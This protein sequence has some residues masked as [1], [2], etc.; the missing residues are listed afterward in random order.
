MMSMR[1]M[2]GGFWLGMLAALAVGGLAPCGFAADEAL[3]EAAQARQV[4]EASGVRGG[5]VVHLGCG[6]GRL[7]A[8]LRA[9]DACVVHGLDADAASVEKAR[10]HI[11]A[12]GLYGPVSVERWTDPAH[13]PY[14]DNLV[15]LLVISDSGLQIS[16][17]KIPEEE[18]LRVLAPLGVAYARGADGRWTK[19]VK[20]WPKD[21]DE[22]THWLHDAGNNAVARDTRVGPPRRMQWVAEPLWS[23]GHEVVS[24]VGGAVTARGRIVYALDEG[25]PG[26]YAL[27]SK[28]VLVA[29]DAFNGVLLWKR[30]I[31]HWNP[32][33]GAGGFGNGFRPRRLVTDGERIFLP[34]GEEAVLTSLGAATGKSLNT[35]EQARGTSQILCADGLLVA[36]ASP[37]GGA[38]AKGK[39]APGGAPV[40]LA[41]RPDTLEVLW[42]MPVAGLAGDTLA[43]GGGRV[44]FMSGGEVVALDAAGGREAWRF[45][46]ARAPADGS[47]KSPGA[48][49]VVHDGAVYVQ[50]GTRLAALAAGTGKEL[51]SRQDAPTSKGELFAAGGL[52]WRTQGAGAVGHDPATGEVRKT[53]D[54]SD[55]FCRGH[56]LR[57]YPSKAT[58]RYIITNNR[59]AEFVSLAAEGNVEND[60]LR[61]NCGHGVMPANGLVY[62]PPCQCMCYP[63]VLLTGFKALAA[64]AGAAPAADPTSGPAPL[65]RGPAYEAISNLKS[66]VA[67]ASDWPT[68]R[69]D[70]ARFG[71]TAAAVPAA[72]KP[73]WQAA[74]GGRLTPPVAAG[75]MLLVAAPDACTVHA[76]DAA[77]GRP[78]WTFTAGGRIDSPPTVHEGLVL[79]GGADGW[80]YCLRAADGA[81]AWRFRAAPE[82]RRIG[83]FGRIESA[84]PVH[85][86]V[87]VVGGVAYVTAG[88]SSYLDGG[89]RLFGLDPRTGKVLHRACLDTW[90][91]TRKDAE[92]KPFI[93]GYHIEGARSDVL[94]SD[95]DF[96]YLGQTKFDRALRPQ[97]VPYVMPGPDPRTAVM[98]LAGQPF[99]SDDA[100]ATAGLETH[101]RQWLERTQPGLLEDLN[102][103]SG[104]Y[105]LGQR[106]M[107]LHVLSTSGFLDDAWFNRTFWMYAPV[108]PGFYLGHRGA[109]TGQLLVV[110]PAKTYSV[111]AYPSRNLQSAMFTPGQKGYL[112]SADANDNDPVLS[113]QTRGTT[114][115]WGYTRAAPPA[116]FRWVPVRIRGM[117]LA[118]QTLFVAGPPDVMDDADP[119]AAFE[120]RRGAVLAAV[121]AAD[122]L[123]LAQLKLESEPVFDGLIASGGRLYLAT[124]DGRV[125]CMGESK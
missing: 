67:D 19:T 110:G 4:L 61:G 100:A 47:K 6:D 119:Y 17:H 30:P 73:L 105:S 75:G 51:W 60:W 36:L 57:C 122:G 37:Q 43:L 39:K 54:A 109:K 8:A 26:I 69:H 93:P 62:A 107:G 45:A 117:V 50:S 35:Q 70:P 78:R 94:V 96:I 63:G 7:T 85:G 44:F 99:V 38:A 14:A 23:R 66:E 27:P 104:G 24:S 12:L 112:L 11:R 113:D 10:A 98:D 102:R 79:A 49:L 86:S 106:W 25:Q 52:L 97:E 76:L 84:W 13:L 46:F 108:W 77:D 90:A 68:Y 91:P 116:W 81:L 83:A 125:L 40:L 42:Q 53:V 118:G 101:Q 115:G 121:S 41:A 89:I 28:W 72:V 29:R 18:I 55:V 59:G 3:S 64:G 21:I 48:T 58:D 92:H 103:A 95:G 9:G 124:R 56:H 16:E 120:G 82:D 31:P 114:K 22:W 20:P 80:V 88:R 5:L 2:A 74:L 33:L 71:A 87:L 1:M 65:E 34:T 111:Q 15:N 123:T 32:P